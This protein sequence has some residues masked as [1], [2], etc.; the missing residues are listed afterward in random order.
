MRR[1]YYRELLDFFCEIKL[2]V[3]MASLT[4]S[5]QIMLDTEW[6]KKC[7]TFLITDTGTVLLVLTYEVNKHC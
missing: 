3:I 1:P 4:L 6:V 5:N 7:K 2:K